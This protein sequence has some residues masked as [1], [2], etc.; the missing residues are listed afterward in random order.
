LSVLPLLLHGS[1]LQESN[2]DAPRRRDEKQEKRQKQHDVLT[3]VMR[4]VGIQYGGVKWFAVVVRQIGQLARKW[5][6]SGDDSPTALLRLVLTADMSLSR[7]D[8]PYNG[9]LPPSLTSLLDA[10]PMAAERGP[11]Y[12]AAA[13]PADV[14]SWTELDRLLDG[15]MVCF[16]DGEIAGMMDTGDLDPMLPAWREDEATGVGAEEVVENTLG[17]SVSEAGDE[18][19]RGLFTPESGA[20]HRDVMGGKSEGMSLMV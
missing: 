18:T 7:A 8:H 1:S 5:A 3:E 17:V 16:D 6:V 4:I 9:A 14:L 20:V 13:N 11:M 12:A 15:G 10:K 2:P 19:G